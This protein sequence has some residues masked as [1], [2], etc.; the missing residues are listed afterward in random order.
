LNSNVVG[1][2][3]SD[4][5]DSELELP[6]LSVRAAIFDPNQLATEITTELTPNSRTAQPNAEFGAGVFR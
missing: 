4:R 3:A 6:R 2:G 1:V 5:T